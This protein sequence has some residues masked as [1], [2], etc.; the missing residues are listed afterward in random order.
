[1]RATGDKPHTPAEQEREAVRDK[2]EEN[3]ESKKKK[4][5]ARR[6]G[7]KHTGKSFFL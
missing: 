7:A 3:N 2:K 5:I 1:M 4:K 6:C